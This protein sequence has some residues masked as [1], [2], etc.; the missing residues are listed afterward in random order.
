[1]G[2]P[3]RPMTLK[4]WQSPHFQNQDFEVGNIFCPDRRSKVVKFAKNDRLDVL[5]ILAKDE[6]ILFFPWKV[7]KGGTIGWLFSFS[8]CIKPYNFASFMLFYFCFSAFPL[9]RIIQLHKIDIFLYTDTLWPR[10]CITSSLSIF[11]SDPACYCCLLCYH[12]FCC[13][14]CFCLFSVFSSIFIVFIYVCVYQV[15]KYSISLVIFKF[16]IVGLP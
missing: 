1:M 2:I 3:S 5:I 16:V 7:S 6:Q 8:C 4:F 9:I 12:Y 14:C 10:S 15:F 11:S 13:W